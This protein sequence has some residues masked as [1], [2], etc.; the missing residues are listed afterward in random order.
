MQLSEAE[1]E[2]Q[3]EGREIMVADDTHKLKGGGDR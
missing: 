1:V 3:S 2:F